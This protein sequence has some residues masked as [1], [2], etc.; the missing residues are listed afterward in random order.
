M[1]SIKHALVTAGVG[2]VLAAGALGGAAV[3]SANPDQFL[4][5]VNV[6][7]GVTGSDAR[8]LDWGYRACNDIAAG[9][10]YGWIAGNIDD[11]YKVSYNKAYFVVESADMFL[12]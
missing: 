5:D 1:K 3:A 9:H 7:G 8:K 4:H 11:Q 12:C 2:A 6:N 10:S